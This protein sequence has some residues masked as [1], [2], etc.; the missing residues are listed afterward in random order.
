MSLYDDDSKVELY[1]SQQYPHG[2]NNDEWRTRDGKVL[3]VKD[4]S[5]EHIRNCMR[6]IGTQDDFY[7]VFEQELKNRRLRNE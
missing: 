1:F 4:M 2:V 7:Y 5:T 6:M 3:K